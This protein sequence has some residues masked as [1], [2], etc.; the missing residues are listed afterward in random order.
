MLMNHSCKTVRPEGRKSKPAADACR[1]CK[2][3]YSVLSYI[4]EVRGQKEYVI[5]AAKTGSSLVT[6]RGRTNSSVEA[7]EI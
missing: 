5:V 3:N 7:E 6:G 2:K 4:A 1:R